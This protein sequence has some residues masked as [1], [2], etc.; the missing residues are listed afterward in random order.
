MIL[1][2]VMTL[3]IGFWCGV[4]FFFGSLSEGG[5][6]GQKSCQSFRC[7]HCFGLSWFVCGVW[8]TTQGGKELLVV[9]CINSAG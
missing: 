4:L 7:W 3:H 2:R 6:N 1:K 8:I 9:G 5:G